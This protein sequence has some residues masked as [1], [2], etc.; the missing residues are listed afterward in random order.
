M[1]VWDREEE[2][3]YQLTCDFYFFCFLGELSDE[4]FLCFHPSCTQLAICNDCE[5]RLFLCVLRFLQ[6]VAS[7][8]REG[9]H[10]LVFFLFNSVLQNPK[11]PFFPH[12]PVS[13]LS[14]LL[15]FSFRNITFQ[16]ART[17]LGS[18]PICKDSFSGFSHFL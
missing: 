11:L 14:S 2:N 17:C 4:D 5:S 13:S 16:T 15:S 1:V 3:Y 6:W 7:I 9:V 18:V 8:W 10:T 12:H